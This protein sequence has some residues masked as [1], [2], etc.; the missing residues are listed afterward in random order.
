MLQRTSGQV[1]QLRIPLAEPARVCQVTVVSQESRVHGCGPPM[2]FGPYPNLDICQRLNLVIAYYLYS[3][4]LPARGGQ[5]GS[6]TWIERQP[7]T[8]EKRASHRRRPPHVVTWIE[9]RPDTTY[10]HDI[11]A[12]RRAQMLRARA[13][14]NIAPVAARPHFPAA[15]G[16]PTDTALMPWDRGKRTARAGTPLLALHRRPGRHANGTPSRRCLDRQRALLSRAIPSRA[17]DGTWASIQM[18]ACTWA[19]PRAR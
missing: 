13:P 4:Q 1:A 9:R 18:P 12:A 6:R 17:G 3:L 5:G 8:T 7:D 2:P 14:E 19:T 15:Y 11:V 10:D 16:A